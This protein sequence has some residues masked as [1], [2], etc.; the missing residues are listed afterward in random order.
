MIVEGR[1]ISQQKSLYGVDTA[2]GV[3][4]ATVRGLLKRGNRQP[5]AGDLVDVEIIGENP[6]MRGIVRAVK[7][8]KNLL[9]RPSIAN[10]DQVLVIVTAR[11]PRIEPEMIDR[12]LACVEAL[13]LTAWLLFNK[14]DLLSTAERQRQIETIALYESIGYGCIEVSAATGQGVDGILSL[15]RG[16]VVTLAGPSGVG[17][18]SL[19]NRIFPSLNLPTGAVSQRTERGTHTTTT[20]SLLKMAADTYLA[21]TPGFASIEPPD[22][23]PRDVALLFPEMRSRLG[24]C[25]FNDCT[26]RHEPG[27]AIRDDVETGAIALRRYASYR[28][29]FAEVD[30]RTRRRPAARNQ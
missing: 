6:G 25:R 16:S 2:R 10:V 4:E 11:E 12:L 21:D 30:E 20:T 1:V 23:D 29:L 9:R 26:H 8:R 28:T 15:C 17:K 5:I 3:V 18:T 7:P 14:T 27:C 22:I 24:R 13:E 19:L